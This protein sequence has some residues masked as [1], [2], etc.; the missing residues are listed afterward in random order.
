MHYFVAQNSKNASARMT[1]TFSNTPQAALILGCLIVF[2]L[3]D[4]AMA[5]VLSVRN[6]REI[7]LA[8]L[9]GMGASENVNI[10]NVPIEKEVGFASANSIQFRRIKIERENC[11][12]TRLQY[13]HACGFIA[14]QVWKLEPYR[15]PGSDRV[16]S[17]VHK[18]LHLVSGSFPP[19][20]NLY[21]NEGGIAQAKMRGF[22]AHIGPEF[23]AASGILQ[24]RDCSQKESRGYKEDCG[25]GRNRGPIG[26][27][28]SADTSPKN[29]PI[30]W[31]R[32]ED[33]GR[34]I[35]IVLGSWILALVLLAIGKLWGSIRRPKR[36]G[37][38]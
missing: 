3:K 36:R 14:S 24:I 26:I 17:S 30:A 38:H 1:L 35:S 33:S 9:S 18:T 2:G 20:F 13:G 25:N 37:G 7:L 31:R 21:S 10:I 11:F 28:V 34:F 16:P 8:K 6:D 4:E 23:G 32:D 12:F 5:C 29:A 27:G 22:N 19:V 15:K